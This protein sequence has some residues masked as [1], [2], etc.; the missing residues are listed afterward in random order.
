MSIDLTKY[1]SHLHSP[2]DKRAIAV[3]AA[4]ELIKAKV[5]NSPSNATVLEDEIA[6]L[7]SYADKIQDALK[8]K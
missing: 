3:T 7:D 5:A 6:D 4:L 2:Q 8:V 1:N